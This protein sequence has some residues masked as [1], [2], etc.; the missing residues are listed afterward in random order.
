MSP[1][2]PQLAFI[3]LAPNNWHGLWMN[4]QHLFSRIASDHNL[5]VLFSNGLWSSW[6]RRKALASS[7]YLGQF[8]M[9]DGVCVDQ[10]PALLLRPRRLEKADHMVLKMGSY[11]L[12]RQ[13]QKL[14]PPSSKRVLYICH[15]QYADYVDYI[16]HDLL[17]Y[18]A[19]DDFLHEDPRTELKEAEDQLLKRAELVLCSSPLLRNRFRERSGRT[20]IELLINGVDFERFSEKGLDEPQ[21]LA[22][23][24]EPRIGYI[25]SINPKL[26]FSLIDQL[27]DVFLDA[28]FVF[29]GRVNNLTGQNEQ[30]WT[31]IIEKTNV[32]LLGQKPRTQIPAYVQHLDASALFYSTDSD[33][34]GAACSP[35]KLFESLAAGVPVISSDIEAVRLVDQAVTIAENTQDWEAAI[36]AKLVQKSGPQS[37][38][39]QQELRR[40]A[41]L[42]SWDRKVDTLLGLIQHRLPRAQDQV[43]SRAPEHRNGSL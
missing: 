8:V 17:V 3:V 36:R 30:L 19:Y 34:F 27:T 11:R 37:T 42:H 22:P 43:S 33:N 24:P 7:P 14:M 35:L 25:G 39:E 21:D 38:V 9:S 23:V 28:S 31:K 12:V 20:D 6:F 16:P 41:L 18:H 15:P 40:I 5:P 13:F 1:P 29:V 26:D 4:R 32:H 10:P 2:T